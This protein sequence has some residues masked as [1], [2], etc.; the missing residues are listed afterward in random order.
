[1]KEMSQVARFE[2]ERA[3]TERLDHS[4]QSYM[5]AMRSF[6]PRHASTWDVCNYEQVSLLASDA[7]ADKIVPV[8]TIPYIQTWLAAHKEAEAFPDADTEMHP[9]EVPVELRR[10]L[11]RR[12]EIVRGCDLPAHVDGWKWFLKDATHLKRFCT[13]LGTGGIDGEIQR[14]NTLYVVSE[15]VE[16]ASEWRAF[17]HDGEILH[18]AHYLGDATAFPDSAMLRAMVRRLEDRAEHPRSYTIDLGIRSR[19]GSTEPLEIHPF[20]ACGL[21]GFFDPA[22]PDMLTGGYE[23]YASGRG[24]DTWLS[25]TTSDGS[26]AA[27]EG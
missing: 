4:A 15:R 18:V 27:R 8:G 25:P 21:Y 9:L 16:F 22:I 14:D 6:C 17:V 23:W 10:F 11:G 12:Y 1:M 5:L 20:V 26:F 24:R 7:N 19:D 13:P 2:L 3:Y